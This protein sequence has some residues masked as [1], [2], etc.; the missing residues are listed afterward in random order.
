MAQDSD[1]QPVAKQ[2]ASESSQQIDENKACKMP[3]TVGEALETKHT[4]MLETNEPD[5]AANANLTR[6]KVEKAMNIN[7]PN[8]I[9]VII[10]I[11]KSICHAY[12]YP[13]HL[14]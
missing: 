6:T 13:Y 5:K 3:V 1:I 8:M 2:L 11:I 9:G 12:L 10:D 7:M 14:L 4:K